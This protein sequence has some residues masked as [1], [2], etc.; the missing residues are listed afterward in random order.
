MYVIGGKIH[1]GSRLERVL[2]DPVRG[3]VGHPHQ[4]ARLPQ[5]TLQFLA[6]V[7]PRLDRVERKVILRDQPR[8]RGDGAGA[9]RRAAGAVERAARRV[10]TRCDGQHVSEATSDVSNQSR[11][12]EGVIVAQRGGAK[13]AH[14]PILPDRF[15]RWGTML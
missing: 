6:V 9:G 11:D 4:G 14:A 13:P 1:M 2:R 5:E 3:A 7:G 12:T 8:H 15:A 10:S